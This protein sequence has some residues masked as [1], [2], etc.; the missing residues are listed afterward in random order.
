MPRGSV[1]RIALVESD[2]ARGAVEAR[3]AAEQL[4]A[5]RTRHVD[6]L[7]RRRIA[8][9]VDADDLNPGHARSALRAGRP[10]STLRSSGTGGA[11]RPDGARDACARAKHARREVDR[12]ERVVADVE[13]GQRAIGDVEADTVPFRR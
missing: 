5:T 11:L 13:R 12:A 7:E 3:A 6:R 2:V 4:L 8:S 9:A 10:G 1:H